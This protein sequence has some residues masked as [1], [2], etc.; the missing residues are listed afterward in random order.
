MSA[1]LFF[2][3]GGAWCFTFQL[4]LH[5]LTFRNLELAFFMVTGS[6][7]VETE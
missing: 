7:Q 5:E 4:Y 6:A 3:V 2:D 1:R